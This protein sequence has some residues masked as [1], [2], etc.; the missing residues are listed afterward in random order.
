MNRH[1]GSAWL[2]I[3]GI[4]SAIVQFVPDAMQQAWMLLPGELKATVPPLAVKWITY[5]L[6]ALSALSKAYKSYR[7]KKQLEKELANVR[8]DSTVPAVVG[9]SGSGTAGG[10]GLR[11]GEEDPGAA[12]REGGAG[13]PRL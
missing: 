10:A 5:T 3:T 8:S 12:G 13:D 11:Q 6:F 2:I 1:I 9:G 4:V 7:E